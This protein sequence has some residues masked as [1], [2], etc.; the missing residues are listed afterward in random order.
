[1]NTMSRPTQWQEVTIELEE[2]KLQLNNL[3]PM[4]EQM[5]DVQSEFQNLRLKKKSNAVKFVK[6]ALELTERRVRPLGESRWHQ[7]T[8]FR[9]GSE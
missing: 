5:M 7:P 1:M 2:K 6:E 8:G 3:N 4:M 9:T